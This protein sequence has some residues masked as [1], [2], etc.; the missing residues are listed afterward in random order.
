MIWIG[1]AARIALMA[2]GEAGALSQ[3]CLSCFWRTGLAAIPI[4]YG[5]SVITASARPTE[6]R[7]VMQ[8]PR[9]SVALPMCSTLTQNLRRVCR[10]TASRLYLLVAL[11][12]FEFGKWRDATE[13]CEW[14]AI[15]IV[16]DSTSAKFLTTSRTPCGRVNLGNGVN[17]TK[18]NI[19]RN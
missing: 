8:S 10:C 5:G 13:P 3:A 16:H 15:A 1:A 6:G 7:M 11:L 4:P 17:A 19:L 18:L 2:C 14:R 9:Y 12:G